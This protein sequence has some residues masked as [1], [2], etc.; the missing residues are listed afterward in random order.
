LSDYIQLSMQEALSDLL[1]DHVELDSPLMAS[2]LSSGM[3]MAMK[4]QLEEDFSVMLPS[5]LLF[6]YPSVISVAEFIVG[7]LG[8]NAL[9]G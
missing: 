6:D 7:K 5:T 1:G 3:A 9:P 2:G 4:G 8:T